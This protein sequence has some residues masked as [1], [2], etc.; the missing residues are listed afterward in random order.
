M[1]A[2]VQFHLNQIRYAA[3]FNLLLFAWKPMMKKCLCMAD[4]QSNKIL[5]KCPTNNTKMHL[6]FH[7]LINKQKQ[8]VNLYSFA[9]DDGSIMPWL[10]FNTPI[11]IICLFYFSSMKFFWLH[12][13]LGFF[14]AFHSFII[15]I[16]YSFVF[17]VHVISAFSITIAH[18]ACIIMWYVRRVVM[19]FETRNQIVDISVNDNR[20]KMM[21]GIKLLIC[22]DKCTG[23]RENSVLC[24]DRKLEVE[25][26]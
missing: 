19:V 26:K 14:C 24:R 18:I 7:L 6:C 4:W 23:L 15:I 9:F 2:I 12:F 21:F 22:I 8:M 13:F 20:T 10:M 1:V 5:G 17:C 25:M 16:M 11:S 3:F